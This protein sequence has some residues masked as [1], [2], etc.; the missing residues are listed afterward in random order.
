MGDFTP[1]AVNL[2]ISYWYFSSDW[3]RFLAFNQRTNLEILRRFAAEGI[4]LAYP[5]QAIRLMPG[6]G[7]PAA[8]PRAQTAVR[9]NLAGRVGPSG[10]RPGGIAVTT[11]LC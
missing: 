5:T 1:S 2:T 6:A 4:A 10:P 7:E 3:W 8:E 9:A 11:Q